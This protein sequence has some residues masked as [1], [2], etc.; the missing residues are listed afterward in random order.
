M[1]GAGTPIVKSPKQCSFL[2]HCHL[3]LG[4]RHPCS[5]S[6]QTC[7]SLDFP[8]LIHKRA[9]ATGMLKASLHRP[10]EQWLNGSNSQHSSRQICALL[11]A[12]GSHIALPCT[13]CEASVQFTDGRTGRRWHSRAPSPLQHRTQSLAHAVGS[14]LP[15]AFRSASPFLVYFSPWF[16]FSLSYHFLP[17]FPP[18]QIL[19][20]QVIRLPDLA[21]SETSD[22]HLRRV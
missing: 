15:G 18:P 3:R 17:P 12:K 1:S 21:V 11:I 13:T 22:C 6:V 19:Q 4:S 10:R 16:R 20:V 9:A 2:Q 7:L 14:A 8:L 5:K